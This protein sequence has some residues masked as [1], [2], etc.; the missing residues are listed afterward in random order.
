MSFLVT[1]S[2][3]VVTEVRSGFLIH[4]NFCC[5][6]RHRAGHGASKKPTTAV[7]SFSAPAMC[8]APE[9]VD[10]PREGPCCNRGFFA[11]AFFLLFFIRFGFK[12]TWPALKKS[13]PAECPVVR[14]LFAPRYI[15]GRTT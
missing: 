13:R 1:C 7:R 11:F 10:S 15:E 5:P 9:A 14:F 6:Q 2:A 3:E 8:F 12:I 4:F